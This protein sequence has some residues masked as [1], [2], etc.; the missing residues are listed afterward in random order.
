MDSA[1]LIEARRKYREKHRQISVTVTDEIY[2]CMLS[3]ASERGFSNAEYIRFLIKEDE[4]KI[5]RKKNKNKNKG[6]S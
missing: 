3:G 4:K 5:L 6:N 2:N 1:A